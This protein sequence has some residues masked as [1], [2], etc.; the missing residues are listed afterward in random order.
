MA[1]TTVSPQQLHSLLQGGQSIELIDVRTP[2]EY[3]AVHVTVARNVPLDQL[4]VTRLMAERRDP[5]APL[6]VICRSGA[7][8]S[9]ACEKFL[10]AGYTNVINVEGGTTACDQAGLPVTRGKAMISLQRQVQIT[11]G[12]FAALGALLAMFVHPY[13]ALLPAAVGAGLIYTGVM[14]SCMLGMF[15][16]RMPWN[17]VPTASPAAAPRPSTDGGTSGTCC[18]G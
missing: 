13:W 8:G 9:Q 11:A 2:L 4:D 15:L 3:R 18:C 6:Y 12:S 10:T 17:Q 14:D 1:V 5:S 16:A 7:R